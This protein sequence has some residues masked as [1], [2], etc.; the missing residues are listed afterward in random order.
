M[1]RRCNRLLDILRNTNKEVIFIRKGHAYHHH[2]E[3]VNY[4]LQLEN[5]IVDAENLSSVI[6]EKYPNLCY[7]IIAVLVCDTCFDKNTK[8]E[9][10]DGTYK[11]ISNIKVGDILANDSRVTSILKLDAAD[12]I[13]Y[14]LKL[15]KN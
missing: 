12:E 13:M 2:A 11:S 7:K 8:I 5:D 10:V 14:N 15:Q 1:T 3:T 6:K 9:M 4:N